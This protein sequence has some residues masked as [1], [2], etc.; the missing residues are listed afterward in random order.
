MHNCL[1]LH[2]AKRELKI[3]LEEWLSRFKNIRIAEGET[4]VWHTD[5]VW[6]VSYL[7]LTWDRV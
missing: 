7:P 4:P 5:G 6:G 1:G 3:V 2:L